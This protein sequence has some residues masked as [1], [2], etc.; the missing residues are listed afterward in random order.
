M[1]HDNEWVMRWYDV[2][3]PNRYDLRLSE[4][5]AFYSFGDFFT[6]FVA[7]YIYGFQRV[8]DFK[9]FDEAQT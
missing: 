3:P 7:A 6:F 1:F 9:K 5:R 4:L 2:H 8:R